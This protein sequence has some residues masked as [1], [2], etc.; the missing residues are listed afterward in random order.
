MPASVMVL[1]GVLAAAGPVA[2]LNAAC[3][4]GGPNMPPF[5]TEADAQRWRDAYRAWEED[6]CRRFGQRCPA[7]SRPVNRPPPPDRNPLPDS[8]S[9]R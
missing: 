2:A 4:S 6:C 7:P 8:T 5:R 1:F 3:L 9:T